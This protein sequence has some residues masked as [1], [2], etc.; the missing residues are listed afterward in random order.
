L[1]QVTV[2]TFLTGRHEVGLKIVYGSGKTAYFAVQIEKD[3]KQGLWGP[4]V[5][6]LI[7]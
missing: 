4:M 3:G 1:A 5:S 2:E 6:A 7:S